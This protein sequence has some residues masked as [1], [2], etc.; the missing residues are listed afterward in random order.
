[1]TS[2]IL[3]TKATRLLIS[4]TNSISIMKSNDGGVEV[5]VNGQPHQINATPNT[6]V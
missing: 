3:H 4:A 2:N 1:M 6:A 5:L